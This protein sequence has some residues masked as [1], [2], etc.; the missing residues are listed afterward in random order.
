M[1]PR[2]VRK[3]S[4]ATKKKALAGIL[5]ISRGAAPFMNA[6]EAGK[7]KGVSIWKGTVGQAV[8]DS[9]V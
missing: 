6:Y 1:T 3:N 5:C 2:T 4:Y 7:G 8:S 9:E